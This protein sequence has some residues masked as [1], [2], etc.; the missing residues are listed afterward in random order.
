[1][2]SET[3]RYRSTMGMA[4]ALFTGA[5]DPGFSAVLVTSAPAGR[6]AAAEARPE[7]QP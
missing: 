2:R 5:E 7:G 6:R 4:S 1:M 3:V